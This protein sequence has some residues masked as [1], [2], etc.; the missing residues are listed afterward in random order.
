MS[1]LVNLAMIEALGEAGI[2]ISFT[3]FNVVNLQPGSDEVRSLS[4]PPKVK[5][6][7]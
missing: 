3:T 7:S 5:P 2:D 4:N 1:N 6:L